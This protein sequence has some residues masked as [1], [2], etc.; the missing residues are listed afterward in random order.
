MTESNEGREFGA[1]A[2]TEEDAV[3]DWRTLGKEE[4][5]KRAVIALDGA[6]MEAEEVGDKHY[7]RHVGAVLFPFLEAGL[8][9]ETG[10]ADSWMTPEERRVFDAQAETEA[11][12]LAWR[13]LHPWVEAAEPIGSDELTKVMKNA[14]TEVEDNLNLAQDNLELAQA[15]ANRQE[16]EKADTAP[17]TCHVGSK[18]ATPCP[19]PATVRVNSEDEPD[20]C[21]AH[22]LGLALQTAQGEIQSVLEAEVGQ[23]EERL[24]KMLAEQE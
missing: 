15:A 10:E 13:I 12:D 16:K 24:E 17:P 3:E 21:T 19:R 5:L 18:T 4:L 14:L 23:L 1:V 11:W 20:Y 2:F 22:A 7:V 8:K 9:K 6:K